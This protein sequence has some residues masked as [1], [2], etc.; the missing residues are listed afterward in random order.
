MAA[1]KLD[2]A[3]RDLR[4]AVGGMTLEMHDL[5]GEVKVDTTRAIQVVAGISGDLRAISSGIANELRM[6]SSHISGDLCNVGTTSNNI[7]RDLRIFSGEMEQILHRL[8]ELTNQFTE[9]I[10]RSRENQGFSEAVV[11]QFLVEL[12]I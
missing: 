9:G 3:A 11:A 4:D 2:G 1:E 10:S 5:V 6:A 12:Q 7:S 8:A